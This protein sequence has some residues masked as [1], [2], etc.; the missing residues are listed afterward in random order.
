MGIEFI[1]ILIQ[2]ICSIL[3]NE[4]LLVYFFDIVIISALKT[5]ISTLLLVLLAFKT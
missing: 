5:Q 4:L 1:Y 2:P 3:P